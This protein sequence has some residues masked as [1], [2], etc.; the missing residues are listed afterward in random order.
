[1]LEEEKKEEG[2]YFVPEQGEQLKLRKSQKIAVAVL[3]VFAIFIVVFWSMQFKNT[4]NNSLK[5]SSGDNSAET[6]TTVDNA[7]DEANLKIQDTD[8]DGLTD[9]DEL[10][11]YSTSPYLEDTDS[12]GY[13]DKKEIDSDNDPNC[14]MG[15]QCISTTKTTDN[16][17]DSTDTTTTGASLDAFNLGVNTT[18]TGSSAQSSGGEVDAKSLRDILKSSGFDEATLSQISDEQ[19]IKL[20]EESIS[21]N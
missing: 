4:L 13:D 8:K 19:L 1:M 3:A 6:A 12:D 5:H 9:W 21:T 17:T 20:Y 10:N 18:E 15:Q 2:E 16:S 7:K 11:T 14:P